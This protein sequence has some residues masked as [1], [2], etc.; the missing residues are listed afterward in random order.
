M[1]LAF[2]KAMPIKP[3][4]L[5]VD[6]KRANQL[7]LEALLGTDYNLV[8]ASSGAEGIAMVQKVP[9]IDVVLMDVQMPEMDGFETAKRIKQ[10]PAGQEI[11][12]IFVTAVFN[13]D[14]FI[15]R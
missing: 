4:V 3:T 13:E 8:L 2:R 1:T 5:V 7:A 12:I 6:D 10:T 14:P 11:P 15:R 9:H